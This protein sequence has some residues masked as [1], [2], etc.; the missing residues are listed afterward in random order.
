MASPKGMPAAHIFLFKIVSET[1]DL[2]CT[3]P[4]GQDLSLGLEKTFI[5]P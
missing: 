1:F 3:I 4:F 2:N 5:N